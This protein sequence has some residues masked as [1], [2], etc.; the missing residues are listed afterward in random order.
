MPNRVSQVYFVNNYRQRSGQHYNQMNNYHNQRPIN[1]AD[2]NRIAQGVGQRPTVKGIGKYPLIATLFYS[3]LLLFIALQQNRQLRDL[4]NSVAEIEGGHYPRIG[5]D[6][7]NNR[8]DLIPFNNETNIDLYNSRTDLIPFSNGASVDLYNSRTDLI[9]FNSGTSVDLYNSRTD[10]IPFGNGASVDLYNSR[11][12][13]I[14]F[15]NG[16]DVSDSANVIAIKY[17]GILKGAKTKVARNSNQNISKQQEDTIT[18]SQT[19]SQE[20]SSGHN[21]RVGRNHLKRMAKEPREQARN[22]ETSL[23]PGP[24]FQTSL[25]TGAEQQ[26]NEKLFESEAK[27]LVDEILADGE[28]MSLTD[29]LKKVEKIIELENKNDLTPDDRQQP[30]GSE[31]S[32]QA[33]ENETPWHNDPTV[34]TPLATGSERQSNEKL[35]ESEAKILVD[36]ILADGEHMSLTDILKKV[37]KI[38]ELENKNDLTPDDRQQPQ[39]SEV[40][41]Q[42]RENETPWHNDPTVKAFLATGSESTIDWNEILTDEEYLSITDSASLA[43]AQ[44]K[45]ISRILKKIGENDELEKKTDLTQDGRQQTKDNESVNQAKLS[46]R[47]S[48]NEAMDKREPS[49]EF[50]LDSYIKSYAFHEKVMKNFREA[51]EDDEETNLFKAGSD[52]TPDDRQQPKDREVSKQARENETPWHNNPTVKTPLATGSERQSN[53]KLFESEA[54]IL[55]DEILADEEYLSITDSASLAAAQEKVI[56]R[57]LKEIGENDELNKKADLAQD[58]RQQTKDNELGQQVSLNKTSSHN[59]TVIEEDWLRKG[60]KPTKLPNDRPSSLPSKYI[61]QP[62][63]D[64]ND[65][66]EKINKINIINKIDKMD[67]K[68]VNKEINLFVL[69]RKSWI[70][71]QISGWNKAMKDP[72]LQELGTNFA[73]NFTITKNDIKKASDLSQNRSEQQQDNKAELNNMNPLDQLIVELIKKTK[74]TLLEGKQQQLINGKTPFSIN[75]QVAQKINEFKHVIEGLRYFKRKQQQVNKTV[76]QETLSETPSNHKTT[77]KRNHWK[78]R[79]PNQSAID[80]TMNS[81]KDKTELPQDSKQQ[82]KDNELGQQV[83]LNETSSHNVTVTEQRPPKLP[84]LKKLVQQSSEKNSTSLEAMNKLNLEEKITKSNTHQTNAKSTFKDVSNTNKGQNTATQ[85]SQK[86]NISSIMRNS[87]IQSN[88]HNLTVGNQQTDLKRSDLNQA[89]AK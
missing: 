65:K 74:Q 34:K 29:I 30:Q 11:T 87:I 62:K 36:E 53:E 85:F 68:K 15:S 43:A 66:N 70:D 77:G 54:K 49:K 82:T 42:A 83:S 10:L 5:P 14:P 24:T 84:T 25:A 3:S 80:Q 78:K 38:I 69:N 55:V 58:G 16:R 23:Y 46:E 44:E 72:E 21:T 45:V 33:R 31:V 57:I 51:F 52:L 63:I 17:R 1:Q 56:S 8:T 28:H 9:P 22:T 41:K 6:L 32:K 39:G 64:K 48:H 88:N 27:I 79:T 71:E 40:S 12:D 81:S 61:K 20:T 26:S 89:L 73:E 7:S 75:I 60:L 13:L 35:F 18:N 86:R 19:V 76:K 4:K 67:D 59:V 50:D 47:S 2:I 37:E